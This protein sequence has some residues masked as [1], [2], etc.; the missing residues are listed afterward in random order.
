M[1]GLAF[2]TAQV[3]R[4][5][6]VVIIILEEEEREKGEGNVDIVVMKVDHNEIGRGE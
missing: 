4:T 3:Q 5:S 2:L 1:V 6:V